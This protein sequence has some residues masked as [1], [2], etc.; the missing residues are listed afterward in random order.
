MLAIV[1]LFSGLCFLFK[2]S[3]IAI[4]AIWLAS[5]LAFCAS[6]AFG[7]ANIEI[8]RLLGEPFTYQWLL[9]ADFLKSGDARSALNEATNLKDAALMIASVCAVLLLGLGGGVLLRNAFR[10]ANYRQVISWAFGATLGFGALQL[11][12][13]SPDIPALKLK[14]PTAYFLASLVSSSHPVLFTMKSGTGNQDFETFAEVKAK[15]EPTKASNPKIKNVIVFVF[16]STPWEYVQ[17]FG[18][19]YPVTPNLEKYAPNA[20]MFTNAYAPAPATGYSLFSLFTS[21]YP[22]IS[23][24]SMSS[25]HPTTPFTTIANV[26]HDKGYSTGFFWSADARFQSFDIFLNGKGFDS[27]HDYRNIACD[28]AALK[29][30]DARWKNMDLTYDPC[31][32]GDISAWISRQS[33]K[34]FF[35]VMMTGMTHYPYDTGLPPAHYADDEKLNAYLNAL[36]LGDEAFG[37]VMDGLVK[38]GKLDSTLVVVLGDHGEA[39]GQHGNFVHASAIYE[40]NMHIPLMLIDG[41]RFN[42]EKS[43]RLA[44]V[45]DIAPTILDVLGMAPPDEWQGR[46][47]LGSSERKHVFFF[48]PW[49][50]YKFGY[51]SIDKKVLYDATANRLE[52]YNL[53]DDPREQ[54]NLSAPGEVPIE[55]L[56]PIAAW[57]QYQDKLM[58]AHFAK[59]ASTNR[60]CPLTRIEVE[61]GGTD[62]EGPP[63]LLV[64]VD[65]KSA[66]T[67]ALDSAIPSKAK[68]KDDVRNEMQQAIHHL[69]K[70]VLDIP[71]T[72]N[73]QKISLKFTNDKWA[74]D[75]SGGDRNAFVGSL[76][77]NGAV[78]PLDQSYLDDDSAGVVNSDGIAMYRDVTAT[79]KGPFTGLCK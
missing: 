19:K 43:E 64:T 18:G 72:V 75:T 32:A 76:F 17:P 59:E 53:N 62:V 63:E 35:G 45:I 50:G 30:S 71:G 21:L 29:L 31:T 66:G 27:L 70:F 14:N 15:P 28:R 10:N 38:S 79:L 49:S 42:G 56:E 1:A 37:V 12:S 36:K 6:V 3:K 24:Q 69:K 20:M 40:E 2:K 51:R 46:N 78:Q 9:Y 5:T 47:L 8:N 67:I 68:T 60:D 13:A 57:A 23:Y 44:S 48:S 16:E 25:Q 11:A 34:P 77:L 4:L 26:L 54:K 7:Y 61:A 39:F 74:G 33:D 52:T 73:P 22:E 55:D 65:G 41:T 58:K